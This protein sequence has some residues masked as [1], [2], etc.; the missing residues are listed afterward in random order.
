MTTQPRDV[1]LTLIAVASTK[2]PQMDSHW[3]QCEG[4]VTKEEIDRG[5]R[6]WKKFKQ[7]QGTII[8]TEPAIYNV[9]VAESKV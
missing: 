1:L 9:F 6:E 8:V 4:P 7:K 5:I 2:Q 3:F